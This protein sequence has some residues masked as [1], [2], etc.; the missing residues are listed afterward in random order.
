MS[1]EDDG[2]NGCRYRKNDVSKLAI[3]LH[4]SLDNL[5][6]VLNKSKERGQKMKETRKYNQDKRKQELQ[7]ALDKQHL[8]LRNDS[9]LCRMYIM[10][11]TSMT[12]SEIVDI[13]LKLKVVHESGNFK[14][15]WQEYTS[16]IGYLEKHEYEDLKS[17]CVDELYNQILLGS[18]DEKTF[19]F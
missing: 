7:K 1:L 2:C 10:G 5:Q 6:L 14:K 12:V 9:W 18:Y 11:K 8:Q 3:S 19:H 15:H 4:G 16:K 13:M 17:E